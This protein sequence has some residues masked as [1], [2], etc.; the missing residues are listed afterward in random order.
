MKKYMF[1]FFVLIFIAAPIFSQSE[2]DYALLEKCDQTTCFDDTDFSAEY[3]LVQDI[4]GQGKSINEAIMYRRD[5]TRNYTIIVTSPKQDLGKGYLQLEDNIWFFDPADKKFTF[6]SKRDKFQ[7]TNANTSDL[8]PQEFCK[9]Y[10]IITAIP[11]KLGQFD[12]TMFELEAKVEDI[13][14]PSVKVWITSDGLIRKKE[15]YSLS[16]QILRTTAIPSYQLIGKRSIPVKITIID[17]LKGKKINE[18]MYYEKTEIMIKN[19]SFARQKDSVFTK[20]YLEL[21]NN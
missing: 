5:K 3:T 15:D 6:S 18:K 9:K 19:V 20:S 13:L 8:A 7:N 4:P 10:K 21:M 12:C 17:N 11:K 1:L 2:K 14:Y 16:G